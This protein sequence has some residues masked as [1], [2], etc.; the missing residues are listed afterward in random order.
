M[1]DKQFDPMLIDIVRKA[2]PKMM[3]ED[4]CSVQPMP[5][6]ALQKLDTALKVS[7]VNLIEKLEQACLTHVCD[8][9]C[10]TSQHLVHGFIEGWFYV[11]NCPKRELHF[12]KNMV[13]ILRSVNEMKHRLQHLNIRAPD[14]ND[15][16]YGYTEEN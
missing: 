1:T 12:E 3:A 8:E 15:N 6:D 11:P 10:K 4:L 7:Y 16:L 14:Y 9:S 13:K 2:V 5:A